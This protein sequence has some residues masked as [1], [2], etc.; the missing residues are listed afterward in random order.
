MPAYSRQQ[1]MV[2]VFD[3]DAHLLV[4]GHTATCPTPWTR[5]LQAAWATLPRRRSDPGYLPTSSLTPFAQLLDPRISAIGW[6][7]SDPAFLRATSPVG[8]S[9][10]LAVAAWAAIHVAPHRPEIDWDDLLAQHPLQWQPHSYDLAAHQHFTN[11]T[12]NPG[13]PVYHLLPTL[14]AEHVA[15]HGLRLAGHDYSAWL[16]PTQSDGRRNVYFG[17]P[18]LLTDRHGATG[19]Y[20]PYITFHLE[21]TPNDPDL[22]VHADLHMAR[23][24]A[25]PCAYVPRRGKGPANITVLL[26]SESGFLT[27]QERRM[28]VQTSVTVQGHGDDARWRWSPGA[29]KL[30]ALL[31]RPRYPDPD[32][33]R[34][35]PAV[36]AKSRKDSVAAYAVHST[37][38]TYYQPQPP[39]TEGTT[40]RKT[41]GHPAEPG[42]QLIDHLEVF[43]A[44]AT[45]LAPLGLIPSQPTTKAKT[46]EKALHP[47]DVS[48]ERH[49]ELE[50]W[51]ASPRTREAL[52][53]AITRKLGLAPPSP[54]TPPNEPTT[55]TGPFT[56]TVHHRDPG[57]LVGGLPRSGHDEATVR[58]SEERKTAADRAQRITEAFPRTDNLRAVVVELEGKDFFQRT[59]QG[60]P[61]TLLKATLPT[62]GRRVQCMQPVSA[63]PAAG[64]KQK[65]FEDTNHRNGDIERA[66][67][68]VLDA[69][70]QVGHI[71]PLP[72]PRSIP[73]G[74][75]LSTVWLSKAP[76]S[77]HVP[78]LIRMRPG[79]E[80]TAQLMPTASH[81]HEPELP[82][83][84]LPE[85]LVAGRGRITLA[86]SHQAV[87]DFLIQALALDS[88]TDRLFLARAAV[89]RGRSLWPWLQDSHLTPNALQL[90]GTS[91][92]QPANLPTA[93]KPGDHK[94]LRIIRLREATDRD[95]LPQLCGIPWNDDTQAREPGH[96]RY[97]GLARL[98]DTVFYGI[99]P[100][101]DQNQTPL[102]ISKLDPTQPQN[103]T[104]S[105]SNPRPL[106][107][108]TAFLQ[109]GDEP[110]ELAMYVHAQRRTHAH[111][112]ADT[113]WP[114]LIHLAE[115]MDEYLI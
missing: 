8:T 15:H 105:I 113:Q 20:T 18:T 53:Y 36:L 38:M 42:Y 45:L 46:R 12:P 98:S 47:E 32:Q 65:L 88:T 55:Y 77:R 21:T 27:S 111:T 54:A 71:P 99:N 73:G 13:D 17:P 97:S 100:R 4:E 91:Y 7:L 72:A 52:H 26:N 48:P 9:F 93:R 102:A 59:C 10:H 19:Y 24:A 89:L 33:L 63:P 79:Q 2:L 75:E 76:D 107:I 90:P 35:D 87:N 60:D 62:L 80:P 3:R 83:T 14:L 25:L 1:R 81:P 115:L 6:D 41:A 114:A 86:K 22:H 51:T 85:A 104:W 82:F 50:L 95:A 68:S 23:F 101:S 92:D 56:L 49:Y 110:A 58:R 44:L 70:R 40:R 94:G 39:G 28:L 69:L 103:A 43:D 29:S 67:A 31:S 37:G 78:L 30:L 61:K 108:T 66:T 5:Q 74:L 106:E 57:D 109:E 16:G 34:S 112:D 84:Q 11:A 96:G 64:T